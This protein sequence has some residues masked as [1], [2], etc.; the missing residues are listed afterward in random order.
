MGILG[1]T[2]FNIVISL[3]HASSVVWD[4]GKCLVVRNLSVDML[5]GEPGKMD[6]C[7]TTIPHL[8][9]INTRNVNGDTVLLD[10]ATSRTTKRHLCKI[11]SRTILYSNDSMK[12]SVPTHLEEEDFVALSPIKETPSSWIRPAILKVDNGQIEIHNMSPSPVMIE[13]N[14]PFADLMQVTEMNL[15]DEPKIQKIIQQSSDRSHYLRPKILDNDTDYTS[16]VSIDP[17]NQLAP[18]WRLSFRELCSKF[19][20]VLNPNPGRYNGHYGDIDNSIDF[21]STPPPSVKARLPNYPTEKLQLMATLMDKL[22]TMG[23]LAKPEDV[24]VV[25]TFVVPS[26]LMPKP[27]KGE[28]RLVSDFT[29]LNLHIRKFQTISPTIQDAKKVLAKY[30][31]N[32]ECDLSHYFFKEG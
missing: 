11:E 12:Y 10:Y 13:K 32:I 22:E 18:C 4:L 7:I 27:E 20:D 16:Q 25:P 6:N 28:W 19:S 14:T 17:D 24:G 21:L 9:K 8:K 23:V 2:K 31:F 5:V 15:S 29:P 3:L 1:Q 26:L 30:K